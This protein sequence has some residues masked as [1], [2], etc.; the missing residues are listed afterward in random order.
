MQN[1]DA[2]R[3]AVSGAMGGAFALEAAR[4]SGFVALLAN[5]HRDP[6]ALTDETLASALG[7]DSP[8]PAAATDLGAIFRAAIGRHARSGSG[9]Q[10]F[11]GEKGRVG[12]LGFRGLVLYGVPDAQ[13]FIADPKQLAREVQQLAGDPAIDRICIVF[14]SPGGAV[15]GV[16]EACDAV[17]AAAQIK[18]VYGIVDSLAASAAYWIASQ[19]TELI[20]LGSGDVGSVGVWTLHTDTSKALETAGLKVTLIHAGEKKVAGNPYQPLAADDRAWLQQQA[21]AVHGEFVRAVA[22]GRKTTAANVRENFGKGRLLR[23]GEALKRGM[24]DRLETADDAFAL[25]TNGRR[26]RASIALEL[27]AMRA[28]VDRPGP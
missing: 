16:G 23:A 19:C 27:A 9:A 22:R 5:V 7:L 18:P 21:D 14:D 28:E 4:A 17:A 2:I 25:V 26:S 6:A 1:L 12:V 3:R 10:I 8:V 13:P 11:K 15:T 24:V 20:S